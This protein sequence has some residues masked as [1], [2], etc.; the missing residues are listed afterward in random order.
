MSPN[1]FIVSEEK[2]P[3]LLVLIVDKLGVFGSS[4]V[5]KIHT[6]ITTVVVT[7]K[8]DTSNDHKL[9]VPYA[10]TI[11][12]IPEGNYSHIF[13][14][15]DGNSETL[16]V[17]EPL[18][19]K[20]AA[21][22]AV[23]LFITDY[24]FYTESLHAFIHKHYAKASIVLTGDIFG[25]E[26]YVS[27]VTVFF[28]A[29]REEGII[30]LE[31]IGLGH[32]Y[33]VYFDDVVEVLLRV[34]FGKDQGKL[35]FSCQR[36]GM[37]ELSLAHTLQKIEPF[38]KIDFTK[39]EKPSTSLPDGEY[40]FLPTY[41][42]VKK[43]QNAFSDFVAGK[44]GKQG[45][46]GFFFSPIAI[47]REKST[48]RQRK[49]HWVGILFL[50]CLLLLSPILLALTYAGI[51]TGVFLSATSSAKNGNFSQAVSFS[52]TSQN[53][54]SLAKAVDHIAAKELQLL[55]LGNLGNM[56]VSGID[57]GSTLS[58]IT[59]ESFTAMQNFTRVVNGKSLSPQADF[60]LAING[61]KSA[62]VIL[63][64]TKNTFPL[65]GTSLQ[66]IAQVIQPYASI[67]DVSPSLFGFPSKKTYLVL[68]QNNMELRPGGGF[69]GSYGLVTVDNGRITDFTPHD[70]YEADGQ[71][72]G[73][74]EP[75][76][77]IRRFIPQQHWYLRDSNFDI[78]F[79]QNG[80]NAAFFL[81]QETGQA[82][83]GVIGI[84][85][86]FVQ[87][88]IRAIGPVY[89]PEYNETVTDAN[90]F[91]LT[92]SHAEKLSFA[93]STQKKEFLQALFT[94]M[95]TKL[96]DAHGISFQALLPIVQAA[97]QKDIVFGFADP[98]IQDVFT[99]N[100]LSSTL[101]DGR[102]T[103]D[104]IFNDITGINEANIGVNKANYFVTR[105]VSQTIQISR[106]GNISGVI[107]LTYKNASQPGVWP[108][109]DYKNYLRVIVPSGAKLSSITFDGVSQQIVPAVTDASV[110]EAKG[111]VVP[112]GLE[113]DNNVESGKQ[114]F[115]FVV[116]IPSQKIMKIDIGYTLSQKM[117]ITKPTFTYNGWLFKQPGVDA[118]PYEFSLTAPSNFSIFKKPDWITGSANTISFHKSFGEDTQFSVLFTQK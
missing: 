23:F 97:A 104:T 66:T 87:S 107:S 57:A 40:L 55:F 46:G 41:E 34:G 108:G 102:Q 51:G 103:A 17:L 84:D 24:H 75:P 30:R 96:A 53:V 110:Y 49:K 83:D 9:V 39:E 88:L 105:S 99:V 26:R 45:K 48:T 12:E 80:A 117:D 27:L 74:V 33:P 11:P 38:I 70:V 109:G 28:H 114:V 18:L 89:V 52:K 36:H 118:Y 95:K 65:G 3:A 20:A 56:L 68:F 106:E 71:L 29:A 63:E 77:V 112:K 116:T 92:E 50:L 7:A 32:I 31:S 10:K 115:G 47:Q 79:A 44:K 90:F 22:A 113:V 91:L 98:L 61:I 25:N 67:L 5:E 59:T 62:L 64:E 111:F 60:L 94:A 82:V 21:D 93:G 85:L 19:Q 58:Q 13:F 76:Y 78:D 100:R 72:K 43:L 1:G 35:F 2:S 42:V 73:H 14:V 69:I 101:W 37:T 16:H 15:W 86:S 54:F 8:N 81:K 4:L 6:D